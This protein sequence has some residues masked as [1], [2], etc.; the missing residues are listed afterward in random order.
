MATLLLAGHLL[1]LLEY[2]V[3]SQLAM[4]CPTVCIYNQLAS[5]FGVAWLL[6]IG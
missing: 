4:A 5:T 3:T 6:A 1:Y 2:D